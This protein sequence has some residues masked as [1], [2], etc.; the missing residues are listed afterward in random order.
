MG[1]RDSLFSA[2]SRQLGHPDGVRGRVIG[3]LLNRANR[4]SVTAAVAAL[5]LHDGETA[6]DIGFGGGFGLT[7][8]LNGVGKQ[9]TVHG[10]DIS[11]TMLDK[12]RRRHLTEER[13]HVHAGSITALPL[14]DSSIDA[15]ITVN[16]IYFVERLDQAF[17]E[18]ARALAPGG[19]IVVGIGDPDAMRQNPVT[20]HGFRLRTVD[21]VIETLI[22]SGLTFEKDVPLG[23]GPLKFHLLVAGSGSASGETDPVRADD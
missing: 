17:T 8:L 4:H 6:A 2:M 23:A 1:L 14:A 19:R 16:T 10:I 21:E 20:R 9:G 22:S 12:A 15:A 13:L 5:G 18:V 7:L 11:E 3:T